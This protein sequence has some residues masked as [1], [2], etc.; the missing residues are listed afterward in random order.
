MNTTTLLREIALTLR[1]TLFVTVAVILGFTLGS[2]V[3]VPIWLQGFCLLPA[4]LLFNRLSD[5]G[6]FAWGKVLGF[7]IVLSGIALVFTVAFPHLSPSD[8][9]LGV[10]V[11][12]MFAPVSSVTRWLE[13]RFGRTPP[14]DEGGNFS[15]RE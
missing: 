3:G 4:A 1:N 9:S 8:R 7:L 13:R 10:V 6:P 12:V 2:A 5:G 15:K 14:A 11:C